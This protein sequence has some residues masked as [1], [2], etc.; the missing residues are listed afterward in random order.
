MMHKKNNRRKNRHIETIAFLIS[1]LFMFLLYPIICTFGAEQ[2]TPIYTN[3]TTGY[4]VYIN[5]D[6]NLLT[7][8][9]RKDLQKIMEDITIYGNVAFK[10][11]NTHS[12]SS[13]KSFISSYYGQLFGTDSGT[14]FVIDM[15]YR[16]I[17]IH[18]N[19]AIYKTITNSYADSITDNV[20]TYASNRDYFSCAA[21]VFEQEL[22]LLKG[23]KIR[24]PMKYISNALLALIVAVIINYFIVKA[25]SHA[26]KAS[27]NEILS[28]IF[29][30]NSFDNN[31]LQFTH[32]TRR[33]DPPSSSSSGGGHSGGG[34]GHSSGG[35]GG[36]HSF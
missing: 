11:V 27:D 6:A 35:G 34:G 21:K 25:Y 8:T 12:Y 31:Q 33:Y 2:S 19:G 23:Q 20:Y 3:E 14:V 17:W 24:Q 5:D 13:T 22:V 9:Q 32:T 16:N 30:N 29:D 36:G 4:D 15:K 1:F 28:G 26:S 10:T 18:S 7:D